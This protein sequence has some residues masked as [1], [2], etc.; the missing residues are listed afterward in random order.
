MNCNDA[1]SLL[2]DLVDGEFEPRER[3]ELERHVA[4]CRTCRDALDE[5]KRLVGQA[6]A[7]PREM[8][9]PRDLMPDIRRTFARGA[10]RHAADRWLGRAGSDWRP[11]CS[12]W[13]PPAPW[14]G[15]ESRR[16]PRRLPKRRA[17]FRRWSSI[18]RPIGSTPRLPRS[19]SRRSKSAPEGLSPETSRVIER[20]LRII[21]RAIGKSDRQSRPI[22]RICRTAGCS[23]HFTSRGLEFLWR[24]TRL[25]S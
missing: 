17:R 11:R 24:V 5:L 19:W 16:P 2:D 8:R 3:D 9:P 22:R 4:G 6:H 21:D 7:L 20:N 10:A 1:S 14:C 23:P 18:A 13:S 12:S 25:S 15:A